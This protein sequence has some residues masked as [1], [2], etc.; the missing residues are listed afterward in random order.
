MRAVVGNQPVRLRFCAGRCLAR[1]M[2]AGMVGFLALGMGLAIAAL[3]PMA[4]ALAG[5]PDAA[6]AVAAPVA[7]TAQDPDKLSVKLG[8]FIDADYLYDLNRPA[9]LDR[10]LAN[11][12]LYATTAER[13][14]EFGINLAFL[15]AKVSSERVRGR[16]A[17]QFGTSVQAT[18]RGE[19]AGLG[20]IQGAVPAE[21]IQEAVVGYRVADGL[22]VDGGIFFSHLGFENFISRDNWVY[23]RSLVAELSPYY[24]SGVKVTYQP[25]A[26]WTVQ[27]LI[28]NGWQNIY[29]TNTSKS[30]GLDLSYSPTDGA[31]L[32]YNNYFGI[33]P[34]GLV[35]FY[36]ELIGRISVGQAVQVALTLDL[37]S[38]NKS[39]GAGTSVWYGGALLARY[40][41]TERLALGGRLER[42]SDGDGVVV[43]TGTP[44][45]FAVSGVSV[46][47]DAQLH[48]NLLWRNEAR[49][50]LSDQDAIFAGL[51]GPL[52][53]D[54]FLVTSVG[55]SF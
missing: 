35:R 4:S 33:E 41:L 1:G 53:T 45:G 51:S 21:L 7:S 18:Y 50:L 39:G 14:N 47:L 37:G 44:N 52:V 48:K 54:K 38:Q 32:T 23:T 30:V 27:F 24:E 42:F 8:G 11:G 9:G 34:G 43:T 3:A 26:L 19:N 17:L 6:P 25:S 40:Q 28:I 22:W 46:N 36:N 55:L 12:N 10:A 29:E 49:L 15:D 31:E 5:V 2:S 13:S 16:L 20:V